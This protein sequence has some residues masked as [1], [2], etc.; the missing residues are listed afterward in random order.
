VVRSAR[1]EANSNLFHRHCEE[2]ATKQSPEQAVINFVVTLGDCFA[3]LA[4]TFIFIGIRKA[5]VH[6]TI[7]LRDPLQN[8][9]RVYHRQGLCQTDQRPED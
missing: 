5:V 4:M 3:P 2:L 9:E 1:C 8:H 6:H 7:I